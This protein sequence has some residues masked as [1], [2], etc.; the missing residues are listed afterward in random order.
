[1]GMPF[2][3][4]G[5]RKKRDH[6]IAIDL[7]QR[8]TKA[9][10]VQRTGQGFTLSGMAL[11]DTPI[12]DKALSVQALAEHLT[13]VGK[14]LG[15]KTRNLTLTVG[16]NDSLVRHVDMP[17][18]PATDLRLIL[19]NNSRAYLQQDL[20]THVFDCVSGSGPASATQAEPAKSPASKHR[21]L[22]AGAKRQLIDDLV[23]GAKQAGF[24]A[25][26]IVPGILGPLNAFELT[27]PEVFAGEVVGLVDIGFKSS[28]IC[29]LQQGELVLNRVV[30]MGGDRL[31]A[32]LA[33]H[34]NINYAEAE[35][36]KLGMPHEVQSALESLVTPLGRELRALI[37][38]FEHQQDRSVSQVFLS[39]GTAQSDLV[40][41]SL[42]H[43]LMLECTAWNPT[44]FLELALPESQTAD[45]PHAAGQLGVAVGAALAAL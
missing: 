5:G 28:S 19:K 25:D 37:D 45:L 21:T 8:V 17:Q 4:A 13:A 6:M 3:N 24:L 41:Q 38:F 39:G 27:R 26:H 36:I 32:G 33:D 16:I 14:A 23:A 22:V 44:A 10:Q 9:V 35:G 20:G 15:A 7:G 31:T 1:M 12:F 2:S 40:V 18:L 34:L 29:I 43:E 42:R 11:M 30:N